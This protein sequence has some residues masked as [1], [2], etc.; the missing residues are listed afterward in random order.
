MA[1][2]V[3]PHNELSANV[4]ISWLETLQP[5]KRVCHQIA[6]WFSLAFLNPPP[7]RRNYMRLLLHLGEIH[8]WNFT[9]KYCIP[10]LTEKNISPF[11]SFFGQGWLQ[12]SLPDLIRLFSSSSSRIVTYRNGSNLTLPGQT[13]AYSYFLRIFPLT[14]DRDD[15]RRCGI[16]HGKQDLVQPLSER[17]SVSISR[18]SHTGCR[19]Q[20][21]IL[22]PTSARASSSFW[23][24]PAFQQWK[25]SKRS[26][27][28]LCWQR[29]CT[30]VKAL[31]QVHSTAERWAGGCH[32]HR[33]GFFCGGTETAN[34]VHYSGTLCSS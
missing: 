22:Q 11:L 31:V 10:E 3:P 16:L 6:F 4:S 13:L 14:R 18:A 26:N 21:Q 7:R 28:G 12:F 9:W 2:Y 30:R 20:R 19:S 15:F 34:T 23:A 29:L 27:P 8:K 17:G 24:T 5:S 1:L 25:G 33:L 32:W